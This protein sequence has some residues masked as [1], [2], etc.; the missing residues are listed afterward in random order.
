MKKRASNG[1]INGGMLFG[2]EVVEKRLVINEHEGRVVKQIYELR[3]QGIGYKAIANTINSIGYKTKKGNNF[4][5]DAIRRIVH[6][7]EYVGIN[8]WGKRR[9]EY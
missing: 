5:I 3:A 8:T 4:G 7:K 2:Y 9:L 1:E 6:N